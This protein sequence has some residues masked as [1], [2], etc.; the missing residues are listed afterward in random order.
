VN[1]RVEGGRLVVEPIRRLE[2]VMARTPRV[3]ISLREF[4]KFRRELSKKAEA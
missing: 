3:E 4:K 2:E 1:Y